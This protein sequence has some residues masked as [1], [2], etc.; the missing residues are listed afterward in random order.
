MQA[1]EPVTIPNPI[2]TCPSVRPWAPRSGTVIHVVAEPPAVVGKLVAC[3]RRFADEIAAC[4]GSLHSVARVAS[5]ERFSDAVVGDIVLVIDPANCSGVEE[6]Y[7]IT[8][9]GVLTIVGG[10]LDGVFYG[11]RTVLHQLAQQQEISVDV[12]DSPH[13]AER[14]VLLD[15]GRKHFSVEWIANLMHDMAQLKLN[16][17]QLHISD[18]LGFRVASDKH[19]EIASPENVTA[20]DVRHLLD[21]A[22]QHHIT[23][24]PDVDTP[25]HMDHLLADKPAWQLRL[26]D[27][28]VLPGHLDYSIRE[29]REF[30]ADIVADI[31]ELFGSPTF[32]LGGDEFFPAPWQGTGSGVVSAE[33]APQLLEFSRDVY[34]PTATIVDGYIA[35]LSELVRVLERRGITARVWNDDV[36]PGVGL[37]KL[38]A[39]VEVDCWVRWNTTK[40][41]AGALAAAGHSLVNANGDYLYIILEE[42]GIGT[43][44]T[45]SPRGIYE[46][47]TPRTFMGAAGNGGDHVVQSDAD[48]RGAHL[49][50]WCDH[51]EVLTEV[52]VG[53][54]LQPWLQAFSQKVWG[55]TPRFATYDEFLERAPQ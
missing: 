15:I 34:G 44:P 35:Y 14:G 40:P 33:T 16:V 9:D 1:G 6:S 17:L 55:S 54:A 52:E 21:L 8:A 51:P 12:E 3:A 20:N 27:G 49:S 26:A 22:V 50:I 42:D 23:I 13:Y 37:A 25:G 48:V 43:G 11:T 31:A 2:R 19:P 41:H 24:I 46:S 30:V 29:A 32:H 18:A 7:T 36:N 10:G 45:K 53:D 47:W 5:A 38:P 39:S 28:T 4:A